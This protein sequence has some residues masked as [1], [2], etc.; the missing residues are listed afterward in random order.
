[1][2]PESISENKALLREKL[3]RI[4]SQVSPPIAEA[5]SQGVWNILR[6]LPEFKKAEGIGA[7]ASTSNE[8]N[9]ISILQGVLGLGKKLYLPRVVKDRTHFDYCQV[10]DLKNLEA[11]AYGILEPTDRRSVEWAQL[12][13]VLVPGLAFDRK[14]NRL[15]FGKGYYDRIL[16]NLKKSALTV[17]LAYSFQIVEQVPFTSDD[18]PMKALLTEKGFTACGK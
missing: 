16:P 18:V 17:G 2:T 10:Q 8:I 9:T 6:G 7:F 11:G 5:A 4:R 13:L 3:E 15:G 1:M 14:G 12:D